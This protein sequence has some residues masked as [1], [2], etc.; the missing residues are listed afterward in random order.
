MKHKW[1]DLCNVSQMEMMYFVKKWGSH[2]CSLYLPSQN[3]E[4][5]G[6]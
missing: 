6:R 1:T 4:M 2:M 3:I 5:I